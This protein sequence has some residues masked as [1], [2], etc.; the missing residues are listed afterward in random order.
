MIFLIGYIMENLIE[1]RT[2]LI[3]KKKWE[4]YVFLSNNTCESLNYLINSFIAINNNVSITRFEIIIK[5]LFVRLDVSNSLKDQNLEHIERKC[6][7]S[8]LLIELI[9]KGYGCKKG[10]LNNKDLNLLKWY[11]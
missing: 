4:Q 7:L 1:S 8:D 11:F 5:T 2:E 6:Q 3:S 9:K 10:M